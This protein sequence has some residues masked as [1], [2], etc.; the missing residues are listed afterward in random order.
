MEEIRGDEIL[1]ADRVPYLERWFHQIGMHPSDGAVA[2][3]WYLN[4][5][6]EGRQP[7]D[8]EVRLKGQEAYVNALHASLPRA[9]AMPAMEVKTLNV[10]VKHQMEWRMF[11]PALVG[12]ALGSLLMMIVQWMVK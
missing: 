7:T 9:V 2:I 10:E 3:T 1:G 8:R 12:A 4:E 5:I 6:S 11:W